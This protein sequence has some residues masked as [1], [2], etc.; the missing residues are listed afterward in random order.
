MIDTTPRSI[1]RKPVNR[2][3][4]KIAAVFG[5]GWPALI[6]AIAVAKEE[7]IMLVM[8]PVLAA[9]VIAAYAASVDPQPPRHHRG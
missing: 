3:P 4:R 1:E 9:L 6:G 2:R 5:M 7:Y 8:V